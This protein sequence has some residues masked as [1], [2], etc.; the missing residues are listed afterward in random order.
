MALGERNAQFPPS[1]VRF[2]WHLTPSSVT[3]PRERHAAPH[4]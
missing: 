1:S 2:R 3:M 4:R